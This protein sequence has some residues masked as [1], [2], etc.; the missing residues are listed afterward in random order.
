MTQA[1]QNQNILDHPQ[2]NT[3]NDYQTHTRKRSNPQ[4]TSTSDNTTRTNT[5][6]I[7]LSLLF[8]QSLHLNLR[9]HNKLL[10][11]L[12]LHQLPANMIPK[13]TGKLAERDNS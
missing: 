1:N 3:H 2:G 7:L 4:S 12:H 6:P 10:Q 5:K 11:L 13:T 8:S 9:T